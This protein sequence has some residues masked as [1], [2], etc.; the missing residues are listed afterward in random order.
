M[1]NAS[2]TNVIVVGAGA[3]QE[4]G[5]PT[6][7]ELTNS[8]SKL[9]TPVIEDRFQP[10]LGDPEVNSAAR[11]LAEQLSAP[12]NQLRH[13]EAAKFIARNM[14]LAPSIDNFI[15]THKADSLITSLGKLAITQSIL[16][17]ERSSP[18]FVDPSN[19]YNRIA[20]NRTSAT[21]AQVFFKYIVAQRD[22]AAFLGAMSN[23]T[24]VS[25]NYDRCIEHFLVLAAQSYFGLDANGANQVKETLGSGPINLLERRLLA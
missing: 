2:R 11:R 25:F 21:W 19:V 8:V 22:F 17:S 10:R 5:F 24:F 15:D 3:S 18:I 4:F 20:F 12:N 9:L 13:I 1:G 23:I 7:A 6:G 16:K 14:L